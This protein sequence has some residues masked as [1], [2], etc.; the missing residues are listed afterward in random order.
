MIESQFLD[1]GLKLVANGY[2]II[3]IYAG[4]KRPG[5]DEWQNVHA[6]PGMVKRWAGNGFANGNIGILTVQNPAIDIDIY[7]A[8][9]AEKME[10][11]CIAEFGAVP[12]RIGRAPK[13]LLMYYTSKPFSKMLTDF[14][15]ARGTKH[16]VEILGE[17][18]QFVAYGIHPDTK[19]PFR[20]TS[21]DE[22]LDTPTDMLPELT[23]EMGRAVLAKYAEF[24][25]SAGWVLKTSGESKSTSVVVGKTDDDALL[26]HKPRLKLSMKEIVDALQY[27]DQ[28]D[29]YDR[30]IMVGMALHHQS[31]GH[32]K[33]LELW[34]EWSSQAHNYDGDACESKWASFT[35]NSGKRMS[36]TFA[37]VLKIAHEREKEE[38]TE[39]FN[40]AMNVLRTCND[41]ETIFGPVAKQLMDAVVAEY[42]VDIVAKK[43]QDRIFELTEVRP[44]I[45]T[46][47]KALAAARSRGELVEGGGRPEWCVGWV[48]LKNGDRFYHVDTKSELSERG[49]NAV[50][51]RMVLKE[52]ER[53]TGV[54]TP[55][56]Q[57]A[58]LA[59]NI[60]KIPTI[61][62]TVYMPGMDKVIELNGRLCANTFDET[63][64]PPAKEPETDEE[65]AAIETVKRHFDILLEDDF[66]RCMVLDYLAYNV[67]H[68]AEKIVWAVVMQG[69][70]GAGK[71][72]LSTLMARVMGPQNVGPVST[73]ELQDKYTGWAEGRKMIF[74]EEIRLHGANRYEVLD[75]MKPYVSNEQV[76]IRRMN[77]DSY[78][79]PNVTNYWMF[80]NYWDGLPFSRMDR[81]YYVVGTWFQTK[82]QLDEWNTKHPNYFSNLYAAITN[83]ADVL[84]HWLL[85]RA[86][87]PAFQPKRPALDSRAKDSMRDQSD[88]SDEADAL[89]DV[90]ESSTDPE[91]SDRLLNAD[92]LKA[93]MDMSGAVV[94]YGRAFNSLLSKAGFHVVG[95]FRTD[96]A[97]A[98]I[99]FYSRT[100]HLFKKGEE[101]T[102]IRDIQSGNLLSHFSDVE[103]EI[104]D[105]FA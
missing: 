37:S 92:K 23:A 2:R 103:D 82:E 83:H 51:N 32:D 18:Q 43:M 8:E 54:A 53:L 57:A 97:Q 11:W 21:L 64:V 80:T 49:F 25:K 102:T 98:P 12:T 39:A 61:D 101:L 20:W 56:S 65:L 1:R 77:R 50:Y 85:S 89:N 35:E 68:P 63:S 71:T 70:E 59:L 99:K 24:A 4:Q 41:E 26:T 13:R 69:A 78:D 94:P 28:A 48:Y 91:I 29:D 79:I 67:Q 36:V 86:L 15:D 22:P 76:T 105:P 55:G 72:V 87:S 66:E 88:G 16:R 7:D 30:W 75:K 74:I 46:V 52:E 90:L 45:E 19:Q 34:K 84:R 73:T 42:Q 31:Q 38:K 5:M 62:H 6:T 27:V 33:G 17:G 10:A 9:M 44:R 3:P 93:A 104:G 47:R 96:P 40:R 95:R 60:Y 81:R 100:P 58:S 14:V